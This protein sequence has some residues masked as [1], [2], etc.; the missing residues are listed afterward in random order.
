MKIAALGPP[1]LLFALLLP[2]VIPATAQTAY[3]VTVKPMGLPPSYSTGIYVDGARVGEVQ[4]GGTYILNLTGERQISVDPYVPSKSGDKGV[5]YYCP[6]NAFMVSGGSNLKFFY[7]RQFYLE[8]RSERGEVDGGGWYDEGETA[9]VRV[10]SKIVAGR[11]GDERYVF[12]GWSGDASGQGERSNPIRIDGPKT[13]IANWK[14]QLA[15]RVSATPSNLSYLESVRWYDEGARGEFA[16][17]PAIGAGQSARYA[18][19]YWSGDFIGQ[20]P[21]GTL[22]MDG[23]KHVVANYKLQYLLEVKVRPNLIERSAEVPVGDWHDAGSAISIPPP[24]SPIDWD[25]G[26]R[27]LFDGWI[28]DGKRIGPGALRV[29]MDSPHSLEAV[30]KTQYYLSIETEYGTA[31]GAGWYDAGS[32]ASFSVDGEVGGWPVKYVFQKWSGDFE[33]ETPSGT[34]T[35]DRPKT[36]R[37]VWRADYTGLLIL[38]ALIIAAVL[39]AFAALMLRLKGGFGPGRGRMGRGIAPPAPATAIPSPPEPLRPCPRCGASIPIGA[40]YCDKCGERVEGARAPRDIDE[41]VYRYLAER[42]G[43]I[44]WAEASEDL[45]LPIDVIKAS[46][47]RLKKSGRIEE[48]GAGGV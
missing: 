27:F 8:V 40:K 1:L 18:F 31:R 37:A 35:M 33:G 32:I 7:R 13:A 38:L 14:R 12:V 25:K 46:I 45:G 42:G 23:P 9:T 15:L 39:A 47:E 24:R 48:G 26:T 28:L 19:K 44:S 36:I 22:I 4:G 5:R 11:S 34:L 10:L 20:S 30:Y 41:D 3:A 16:V 21:N 43:S 17:P 6:Q 29:E 2:A